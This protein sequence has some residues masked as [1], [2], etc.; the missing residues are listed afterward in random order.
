MADTA[1]LDM[2]IRIRE[3][4]AGLRATTGELEKAKKASDGFLGSLKAG[5]GIDIARRGLELLKSNVRDLVF[6][7]M[8]MA[9]AIKDGANNLNMSK[10]AYQVLG[11]VIKDAGGEMQLLQAAIANNNRSL[12]EARDVTS[13]A[14][15]S[16]RRLGLDAMALE[17]LPIE[18]RFEAIGKAIG[19]AADKNQA[20][21][22]AGKILVS[23]NLPTLL[24][25]LRDLS[26]GYDELAK[27]QISGG[28]VM[29]DET[30]QQLEQAQKAIEKFKQQMVIGVGGALTVT[31]TIFAAFKA[32]PVQTVAAFT[33]SYFSPGSP[34]LAMWLAKNSKLPAPEQQDVATLDRMREQARL[35]GERMQKEMALTGVLLERQTADSGA[36]TGSEKRPGLLAS[37][38]REIALRKDILE[39]V[40][41]LDP[42][43]GET[44]GQKDLRIK[45]LEE[46]LKQL[47]NFKSVALR[48]SKDERNG[49]F[50]GQRDLMAAR[51]AVAQA[52]DPGVSAV[53]RREQ[54][55]AALS[56]QLTVERELL[57]IRQA[58]LPG[59][60][61]G[62]VTPEQLKLYQEYFALLQSITGLEF[63]RRSLVDKTPWTKNVGDDFTEF[64]N[65]QRDEEAGGIGATAGAIAGMQS[66]IMSLGTISEQVAAVMQSSL[67]GAASGISQTIQ[68]WITNTMSFGQGLKNIGISF[69]QSML[70]AFADMVANYAVSKAA[71]FAIDVATNAKS[72]ALSLASAAKSLVAWIPSAIAASISSFGTAA[73]IGAAAVVAAMAFGGGFAEGGYTGGSN[74]NKVAGF[75]HEDEWVSPQWMK[76][77]PVHGRT[78]A[79]L[80]EARVRGPGASSDMPG[81]SLGGY[82]KSI[83]GSGGV[84]SWMLFPAVR[85]FFA[86]TNLAS[87]SMWYGEKRGPQFVTDSSAAA[88]S[89]RAAMAGLGSDAATAPDTVSSGGGGAGASLA[90]AAAAASSGSRSAFDSESMADRITV[91]VVQSEREAQSIGLHSRAR[92]DVVRI[93]SEDFGLPPRT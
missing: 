61:S 15:A 66:S 91:I 65:R 44:E 49:W 33:K 7:S 83:F 52:D 35:L 8:R 10:E 25:A 55:A 85:K 32:N 76:N 45:T 75:A 70:K 51:M 30:V 67:G 89:A 88:V 3:D 17:Q 19:N 28:R 90:Q 18:R 11:N 27:K 20:F 72:L 77:H 24:G 86:K 56:R 38:D 16:Y 23:R 34:E 37:L 12:V 64:T 5:F 71:M 22:D 53:Q 47:G 50:V 40:R 69:G 58:E 4:I 68:G 31:P 41:Q 6:E 46:Q 42:A 43:E 80:E 54:L 81:Y 87:G 39:L 92:G 48:D 14:A 60:N 93:V 78:I 21:T 9:D 73:A 2:L 84:P 62:P 36:E 82:V 13:A 79:S 63:Q 29:A 1:T 59:E 26:G 74:P 57:A